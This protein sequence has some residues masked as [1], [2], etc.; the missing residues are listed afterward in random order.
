LLGNNLFLYIQ[1]KI[2]KVTLVKGEP[3]FK[4]VIDKLSSM[5]PIEKLKLKKELNL[6][7]PEKEEYKNEF[8]NELFAHKKEELKDSTFKNI[9]CH[10]DIGA[11]NAVVSA[12]LQLVDDSNFKGSRRA[13]ILNPNFKYVGFGSQKVKN[14]VYNFFVFAE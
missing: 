11:T 2:P 4:E 1:D 5:A 14:K 9:T 3:A 13:N 8:I 10:Y 12:A 7:I 6:E